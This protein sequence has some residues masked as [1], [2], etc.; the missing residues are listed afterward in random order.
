MT[1][2]WTT[3]L[4]PEITASYGVEE[5]HQCWFTPEGWPGKGPAVR[6]LIPECEL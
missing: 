4:D 1:T 5:V 3:R 6:L 2:N